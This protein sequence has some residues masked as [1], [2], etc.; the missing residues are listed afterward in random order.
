MWLYARILTSFRANVWGILKPTIKKPNIMNL[1]L[2]I[3]LYL[4]IL[5]PGGTYYQ[6]YITDTIN[7]IEPQ[8][9]LIEDDPLLMDEVDDV[10]LPQVPSIIIVSD[11]VGG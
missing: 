3:L 2:A 6:S 7:A 8:I 1:I 9:E 10:Y 11:N 4:N 5:I